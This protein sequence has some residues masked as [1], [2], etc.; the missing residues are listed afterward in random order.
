MEVKERLA[1]AR[2]A[3]EGFLEEVSFELTVAALGS[4]EE[5]T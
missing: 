4:L 3:R 5:N 2:W 1:L